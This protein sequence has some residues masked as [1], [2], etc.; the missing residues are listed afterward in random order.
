MHG[1]LCELGAE[2]YRLAAELR[3]CRNAARRKMLLSLIQS[4]LSIAAHEAAGDIED[5]RQDLVAQAE[6]T[7]AERKVR[8]ALAAMK[9]AGC[10]APARR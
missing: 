5:Y 4:T 1:L 10:P 6:Q 3:A 9:R 2:C 7:R 8:R